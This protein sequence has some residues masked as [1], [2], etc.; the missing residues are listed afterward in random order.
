[1]RMNHT[2]AE[3]LD[4]ALALTE[5]AALAVALEAGHIDLGGRLCEREMM[6][7]KLRLRI[8]PEQLLCESIQRTLKVCKRHMLVDDEALDLM[9]GRGMCRIH[10]IGT[11]NTAGADHTDRELTLLHDSCLY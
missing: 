3:D 9:E 2:T 6:R 4:P 8:R 10:G 1:M 7:A 5:A 11:E